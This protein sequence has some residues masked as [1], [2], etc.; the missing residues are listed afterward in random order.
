MPIHLFK[1]RG[2]L[3][4]VT[5]A[6][7]GS[8]VYYSMNVLWPQQIA[9]LFPGSTSHNG[10]LAVSKSCV[11]I[12]FFGRLLNSLQ[13]IIGA[14]TLVGQCVGGVLCQYIPKSRYI[15]ISSC[16]SL[17]A[18]SASMV[19]LSPG[20]EVRGI[21]LM[22]MACFSV[23]VIETC[24]LTLAPLACKS[25]D[26]GAALGALG[27]IRSAGAS[28]AVAIYSTILS[29]KLTKFVPEQVTPAALGAGLPAS[30]LTD[31]Y[32]NLTAGT[33]A[34]V[35]G[36]NA[37]IIAAVNAANS[38]AAADAFRYGSSCNL[39]EYYCF[40]DL[41]QICMVCSSCIRRPRNPCFL[42]DD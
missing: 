15:L 35:P 29:E 26:L 2:Y 39:R 1:S 13:C 4:M 16:V 34:K 11:I 31:L 9:Y 17:T 7:V 32:S 19:S 37:A 42:S 21:A 14:A 12:P 40:T 20:Q 36:I 25:E 38:E 30:S 41:S 8:C 6:M 5:T 24:S 22:F 10:W 18:F 23:G 33:L 28:L 27:S 3:A